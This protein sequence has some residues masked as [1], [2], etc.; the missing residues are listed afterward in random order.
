MIERKRDETTK[1]R[2]QRFLV[3]ALRRLTPKELAA[4]REPSENPYKELN[5]L[6]DSLGRTSDYRKQYVMVDRMVVVANQ[7]FPSE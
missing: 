4:S 1:G 2:A 7:L 3:G 5:Q 6:T